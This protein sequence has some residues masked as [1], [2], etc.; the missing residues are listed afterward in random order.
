MNTIH[1]IF[2]HHRRVGHVE[3][4]SGIT[5]KTVKDPHMI[6]TSRMDY[7]QDTWA[8]IGNS[9]MK[10]SSTPNA[11]ENSKSL[12]KYKHLWMPGVPQFPLMK[13]T[14][15]RKWKRIRLIYIILAMKWNWCSGS[16][17]QVGWVSISCNLLVRIIWVSG[18]FIRACS[19][20]IAQI[21]TLPLEDLGNLV[22]FF[23]PVNIGKESFS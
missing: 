8:G 21:I 10:V 17:D 22:R 6:T 5:T 23:L 18:V 19:F 9:S 12:T 4:I 11:S 7:L 13:S 20:Q 2:I 1:R 16:H 3:S 15:L 14:V